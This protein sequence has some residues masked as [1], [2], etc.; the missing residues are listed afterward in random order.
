MVVHPETLF[1]IYEGFDS[2]IDDVPVRWSK[3][4]KGH[5]YAFA[6]L[7]EAEEFIRHDTKFSA[8]DNTFAIVEVQVC[9]VVETKA[10]GEKARMLRGE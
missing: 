9:K 6:T 4:E 2:E 10:K 8:W 1:F 5:G 3:R 7:E